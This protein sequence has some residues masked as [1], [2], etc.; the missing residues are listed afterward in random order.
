MKK[1][2]TLTFLIAITPFYFSQ[3]YIVKDKDGFVNVRESENINS[4]IISKLKNGEIV[5]SFEDFEE[6]KGNWIN[7]DYHFS[8]NDFKNGFVYKDRLINIS[9][10]EKI[11]MVIK[12][13]YVILKNKI[14]EIKITEKKFNKKNHKFTFLKQSKNIIIKID[15]Q[16]Y[17][18]TDG[19]LPKIEYSEIEISINGKKIKLPNEALKNLYEPNS[20]S[21]SAH[22]DKE[23][24]I[25]YIDSL[26]SDGAG[27]YEVLWIIE[28]GKFSK[29]FIFSGC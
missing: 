3:F 15:N 27:S 4:K 5:H 14:F 2:I 13:N 21:T 11:P 25:L 24:D 17:Y 28:K 8:K 23:N 16:D 20:Y 7:V 26:N 18:G 19:Y 12:S 9:N 29:R 10:Y 1:I 6:N 22:Y